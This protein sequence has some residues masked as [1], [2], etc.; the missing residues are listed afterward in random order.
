MSIQKQEEI[1]E[2]AMLVCLSCGVLSG[3][4]SEDTN[5]PGRYTPGDLGVPSWQLDL[6]NL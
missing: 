2:Q 5:R 6:V 3:F 1:S 4:E